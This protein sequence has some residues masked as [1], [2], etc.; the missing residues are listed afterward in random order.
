MT[1]GVVT[2][3]IRLCEYCDKTHLAFSQ[4]FVTQASVKSSQNFPVC[5]ATQAHLKLLIVVFSEMQVPWNMHGAKK[6]N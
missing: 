4:G 2:Q 5:P 3:A 6:K 1:Y